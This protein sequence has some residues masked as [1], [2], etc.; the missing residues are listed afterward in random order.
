MSEEERLEGEMGW[1]E[2]V[3]VFFDVDGIFMFF[4]KVNNLLGMF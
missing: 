4:W 3:I 2:G 1:K